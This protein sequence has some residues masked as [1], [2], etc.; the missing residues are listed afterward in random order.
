MTVHTLTI[1]APF[2]KP[3]GLP[4]NAPD[5]AAIADE[6]YQ[7]AIEE[8]MALRL[9][10][11]E[12]IANNPAPPSFENTL[13]AMERAGAVFRRAYYAFSQK[14]SANINPVL[15][16]AEEALAPK[17]AQ[18]S[19]AIFLNAA[20]LARVKAVYDAHDPQEM[21]EEETRLL[22]TVY[23]QFVHRGALLGDEAKAELRAINT[24]ISELSARMSLAMTRAQ[25]EGALLVEDAAQLAGLTKGQIAAAAAGA[26][27]KGHDGQYLLP[28]V[29]TTSHPLLA[30]LENRDLR[31]RLYRASSL[32]NS[33]GEHDTLAAA[34]E[35]ISLR[36]RIAALFGEP[37]YAHHQMFDRMVSDPYRAIGFMRDMIPALAQTQS[38]EA[39]MIN[40][41]I[42]ED[43]HNFTV[44]PW[45][46]PYYAEMIRRERYDLDKDAIAEYLV[47]DRVLEE[48]AF[49][50]ANALYGLTFEKRSDIPVYH[51]DVTVYTVKDHDGSDLALFYFDP[52]ARESKRGGAW[53]NA[54]VSQSHLLGTLP[55]IGNT[56]NITPPAQGEPALMTWDDVI[57]L[58]H[59]FGHALHAMLSDRTYPSL[60]GTNTARDWVELPS[61][62]HEKFA[63]LPDV[64]ARYARHYK[65]GEPIPA[66]MIAAMKRAAQFNQGYAFGEVV[67][68]S[69]LDME[70]HVLG[71]DE[72][73]GDLIAFE[74]QTLGALGLN[75]DLVPPRYRTPYYRHIFGHE[76]QAGYYAYTWTEMLHHDAFDWVME[77]GGMTRAMGDHAR[78]S[79]LDKGNA[80]DYD[81]MF[82]DFTGREPRMEPML[83]ARGLLEPAA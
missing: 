51:P 43:G 72:A 38:R 11:Y 56:Q 21:S 54:F 64:L 61:Q 31:E 70:L 52:F 68:A 6:D 7:A 48:G 66:E 28:L 71:P 14:V 10:E 3:S 32:R 53:M 26:K 29:N 2:A 69:L 9:A 30:S 13:V 8:A 33:G 19:D 39:A 80:R 57:T 36:M 24:R 16:A 18:M 37:T 34:R 41:R 35:T 23:A 79:F 25:N 65:T 73:P 49:H 12:A 62:F 55:V 63:L 44:E 27:A 5:F 15:A 46:W 77:N 40:Q 74:Q 45:D 17:L 4:F 47:V 81:A 76:Y 22:E 82:R 1:A 60:S 78:A 20:L 67:A 75:T 50:V 59:E 58:F 83:R 42:A